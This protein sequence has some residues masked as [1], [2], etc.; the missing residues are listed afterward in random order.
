VPWR[1]QIWS[2][3][4]PAKH[5]SVRFFLAT[6]SGMVVLALIAILWALMIIGIAI[7]PTDAGSAILGA[8]VITAPPV[9]LGIYLLRRGRGKKQQ[10]DAPG[11]RD[12]TK[13]G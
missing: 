4:N 6:A 11:F 8:I 1:R 7:D 3:W 5:C 12:L 10:H 2:P 9:A 13:S